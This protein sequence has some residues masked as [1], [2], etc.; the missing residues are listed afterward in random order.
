VALTEKQ[1]DLIAAF[2]AMPDTARAIRAV[3]T[4]QPDGHCGVCRS[5]GIQAGRDV[6]PCKLYTLASL[7]LAGR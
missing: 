7:A 4:R 5:G 3:H 2:A 1:Q 6:H